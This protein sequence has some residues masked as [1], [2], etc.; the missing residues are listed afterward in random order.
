[1]P[2]TCI[3]DNSCANKTGTVSVDGPLHHHDRRD[4][5]LRHVVAILAMNS[6]FD[7]ARQTAR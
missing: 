1:M 6:A 5:I 4:G 2:A 3:A 7:L